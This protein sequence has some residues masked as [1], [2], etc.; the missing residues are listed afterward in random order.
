[1]SA[2]QTAAGDN[3]ATLGLAG[4][5]IRAR[6]KSTI[7]S[8]W[9]VSDEATQELMVGLY[10]NLASKNLNKGESLRQAQQAL[11]QNPKYRSPYF[12]APFVLVGNWQ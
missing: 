5:A 11:L 1:L 7:A 10:Q 3:R 4:V 6:A 2:C 12:W 9:S 8:L